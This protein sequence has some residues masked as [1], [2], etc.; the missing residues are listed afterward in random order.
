MVLDLPVY[1]D[2]GRPQ[3][4]E[5][6]K[7]VTEQAGFLGDRHPEVVPQPATAVPWLIWE[8]ISRT[9]GV[10]LHSREDGGGRRGGVRLG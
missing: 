1:D 8:Q 10:V 2:Q 4:D 3:T 6:G 5:A 9:A 7:V